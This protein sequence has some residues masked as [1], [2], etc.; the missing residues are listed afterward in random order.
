MQIKL[1]NILTTNSIILL[2]LVVILFSC[3]EKY[4]PELTSK[5]DH[6]LVVDGKITN[7]P[8]PY[9]IT[10][11]S[12]T[13]VEES[14]F[15]P[16]EDAKVTILDNADNLELLEEIKPGVYQTNP[17]GI[18]GIIGHKYKISIETNGK[19]YESDF[20]ELRKPIKIESIDAVWEKQ[21]N[22]NS[23]ID[24]YGFQ[25]YISTET[26][27]DPINYY[28]W[29][30][31]ETY[32]YQAYYLIHS[33]YWGENSIGKSGFESDYV[34][35]DSLKNCWR[36]NEIDERF[37]YTTKNLTSPKITRLPLNFT[38]NGKKFGFK[39][40]LLVTQYNISEEA[41]VFLNSLEKQNDIEGSL[42][43]SQ[44]YQIL[45]NIH[46]IN[47]QDEPVLGYFLT[48]AV[49]VSQP[50]LLY[51]PIGYRTPTDYGNCEE[52]TT[53]NTFNVFERVKKMS[54]SHWPYI[55]A[56]HPE[57]EEP[58]LPMIVDKECVDCTAKGGVPIKPIYWDNESLV[59]THK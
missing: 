47:D 35:S 4:W 44:P 27:E 11:S 50:A 25:F 53:Y 2:I 45:G 21:T 3:T 49:S 18:Q 10:L 40:A 38:P 1:Q 56:M 39:Y 30:I 32:H 7:E 58:T 14:I 13:S 46:N 43:T 41:Y 28:Y 57:S 52:L 5:F 24:N 37:T 17:N 29:E 9:T 51:R 26:A 48:A 42:Y 15:N 12:S 22:A 20:E 31:N 8:G 55:M 36:T 54:S 19:I 23:D 6:L 59:I 33:I 16:L 34:N